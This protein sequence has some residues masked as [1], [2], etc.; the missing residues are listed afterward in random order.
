MLTCCLLLSVLWYWRRFITPVTIK[1][2]QTRHH[3][4]RLY[5]KPSGKKHKACQDWCL[6]RCSLAGNEGKSNKRVWMTVE[7]C[8]TWTWVIVITMKVNGTCIFSN[9]WQEIR[10]NITVGWRRDLCWLLP[11]RGRLA[12]CF[13]PS[14][15]GTSRTVVYNRTLRVRR[16]DFT[17]SLH[18]SL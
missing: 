4:T 16:R 3:S 6:L 18:C 5:D 17:A 10:G 12:M 15:G 13:S 11:T 7:H 9:C 1:P 14:K 8:R 2:L